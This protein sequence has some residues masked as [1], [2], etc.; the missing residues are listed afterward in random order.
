MDFADLGATLQHHFST[1]QRQAVLVAPFVKASTLARVLSGLRVAATPTLVTRWRPDELAAGVS[2]VES[3]EIVTGLGGQVLLRND[4]HAKY[5]RSDDE[6][7]IGSANLTGAALGWS[8]A[9]NL[10]ALVRVSAD[11]TTEAFEVTLLANAV[12]VDAELAARF[13]QLQEELRA[14]A[15]P[16]R[17]AEI[18][19]LESTALLQLLPRD[20]EDLWLYYVGEQQL[21][22][23][24]AAKRSA[25]VLRRLSIPPGIGDQK[26][27]DSVVGTALLADPTIAHFDAF[28]AIPRRFGEITDVLGSALAVDRGEATHSA[29]TLIRW[30]LHFMPTRFIRT[31]PRHTEVLVRRT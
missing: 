31:R 29:Q 14:T 17:T 10:E 19:V 26:R 7:L 13:L 1:A 24:E 30:L 9:A 25:A 27:F 16:G 6:I 5:Y 12:S 22:T 11:E 20:P 8:P 23:R 2:D 4:L 18:D 28:V 3:Y 15:E 21:L